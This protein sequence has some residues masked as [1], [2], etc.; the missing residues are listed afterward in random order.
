MSALGAGLVTAVVD[1]TTDFLVDT[2]GLRGSLKV[3]VD[4]EHTALVSA[5]QRQEPLTPTMNGR[6][7]PTFDTVKHN[8]PC[9]GRT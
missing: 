5:L 3:Q 2:G 8:L 1:Q 7:T 4:G 6:S 9:L